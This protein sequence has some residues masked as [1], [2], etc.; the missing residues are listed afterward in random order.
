[1]TR[2]MRRTRSVFGGKLVESGSGSGW[3]IGAGTGI[4]RNFDSECCADDEG[5]EGMARGYGRLA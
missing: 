5:E 1:M 2:R 4:G 3:G